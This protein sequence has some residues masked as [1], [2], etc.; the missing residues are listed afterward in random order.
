MTNN[1]MKKLE[2]DNPPNVTNYESDVCK[3][4]LRKISD[5]SCVYCTIYESESPGATF[6]VDHFRPKTKFPHYTHEYTNLRYSCPRCNLIKGSYWI[7]EDDGCIK[8]CDECHTKS[9][10]ENNY[11][12][13]DTLNEDPSM[14]IALNKEDLLEATNASKP[15]IHTIKYLRL[16]RSQLIKLRRTRRLIELWKEELETSKGRVT[17]RLEIIADE[18]KSFDIWKAANA[19][20]DEERK[21]LEVITLLFDMLSEESNY[22]LSLINKELRNIDILIGMRFAPDDQ[23]RKI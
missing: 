4:Y 3:A 16:N 9:C 8:N 21:I 18:R 22:T 17:A 7:S 6:H 11:R 12:L 5:Y 2:Y 14:L 1:I 10:H 15:A 19:V 23:Y 13:I 20:Y